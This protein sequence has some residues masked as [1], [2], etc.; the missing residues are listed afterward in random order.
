MPSTWPGLQ[1]F[2]NESP[3]I[4][5]TLIPKQHRGVGTMVL[6]SDEEVYSASSRETCPKRCEGGVLLAGKGAAALVP[7]SA[8]ATKECD[9]NSE[10]QLTRLVDTAP[11]GWSSQKCRGNHGSPTPTSTFSPD[12]FGPLGP[13]PAVRL[14]A[15]PRIWLPPGMPERPT[16]WPSRQRAALQ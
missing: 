16:P 5:G 6:R 10:S 7:P 13:Q 4:P 15:R 3:M 11:S 14:A 1:R 9:R 2:Q 8:A 12:R